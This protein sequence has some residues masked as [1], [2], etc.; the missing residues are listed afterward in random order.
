[1]AG[2]LKIHLFHILKHSFI[3][4]SARFYLQCG[5]GQAKSP[6][7]WKSKERRHIARRFHAK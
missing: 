6:G 7:I 2:F 5:Q 1:M 3:L 4:T